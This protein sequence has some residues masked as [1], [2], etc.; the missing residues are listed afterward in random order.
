MEQLAETQLPRPYVTF[1]LG[2][3]KFEVGATEVFSNLLLAERAWMQMTTSADCGP[4]FSCV[5]VDSR[6]TNLKPIG[7]G[8]Y[9]LV[10]SAVDTITG[11]KVSL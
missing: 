8:A 7:R 10:A 6:Y 2:K 9:G 5:Q 1:E 11:K 3:S 4:S